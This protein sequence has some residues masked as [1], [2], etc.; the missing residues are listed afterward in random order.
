MEIKKEKNHDSEV[1]KFFANEDGKEAGHA[2]LY[3]IYNQS[4]DYYYALLEDVF[5]DENYRKQGLGT[6]LVT[7]IIEEAKNRNCKYI[8]G[9]SRYSRSH[10][11]EWY[12]KLGFKD[13]GKKFRMNFE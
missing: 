4:G 5:V 13:Y 7:A 10:I 12:E 2:Y 11:H 1:V 8:M 9:T 6:E 3:L